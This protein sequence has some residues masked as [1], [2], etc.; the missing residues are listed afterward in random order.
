MLLSSLSCAA[1]GGHLDC[2]QYMHERG[3]PWN[4]LTC[5][6]AAKGGHLDCLQYAQAK[7][8]NQHSWLVRLTLSGSVLRDRPDAET[9]WNSYDTS[10]NITELIPEEVY[11]THIPVH[12][13]LKEKLDSF[14]KNASTL[15]LSTAQ[16]YIKH[17]LTWSNV[18]TEDFQ[19]QLEMITPNYNYLKQHYTFDQLDRVLV[20]TERDRAECSLLIMLT[21]EPPR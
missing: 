4:E 10:A 21:S 2:L 11:A 3:C 19:R 12:E 1:E 7:H 15:F 18:R 16:Q 13:P 5:T 14:V 8:P 17:N 6:W 20:H 9:G